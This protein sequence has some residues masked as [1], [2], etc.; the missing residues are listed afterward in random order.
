MFNFIKS[1]FQSKETEEVQAKLASLTIE[2]NTDGSM[3]ILCDWPDF[4]ADNSES[5]K[6]VSHYYALTIH[7]VCSGYLKDDIIDTLKCYDKENVFNALFAHNTII[8][9]NNVEKLS[10]WKKE[11]DNKPIIS[12]LDV[13]NAAD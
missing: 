10:K 2:V 3:N 1:I 9:L 11:D 7:A 6:N 12:P 4:H 8:E 5:L 13:F